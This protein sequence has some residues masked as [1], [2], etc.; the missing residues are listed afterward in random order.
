MNA[1]IIEWGNV[2]AYAPVVTPNS[3]ISSTANGAFLSLISS[4]AQLA[5]DESCTSLTGARTWLTR[6]EVKISEEK[7]VLGYHVE[8]RGAVTKG[9]GAR[10]SVLIEIGS[11]SDILEFPYDEALDGQAFTR[12]L[13]CLEP[14]Q[15]KE[16]D[17]A[18]PSLPPLSI[19]VIQLAQ[20][21]T[22]DDCVVLD[23]DSVDVRAI[24]PDVVRGD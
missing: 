21:R 20:R 23:V 18:R 1:S 3:A 17:P 6:V 13:F 8:V 9:A 10:A 15:P 5:L 11:A 12:D 7:E 22:V 24:F 19:S 4:E 2:E 14:R 16:N